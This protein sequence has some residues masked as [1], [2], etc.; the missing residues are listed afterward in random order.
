MTDKDLELFEEMTSAPDLSKEDEIER[1]S[2]KS[3]I[4]QELEKAKNHDS[5][6]KNLLS[7]INKF[8]II[9]ESNQQQIKELKIIKYGLENTLEEAIKRNENL[10]F[11]NHSLRENMLEIEKRI[12]LPSNTYHREDNC[13]YEIK[14]LKEKLEKYKTALLNPKRTHTIISDGK[15]VNFIDVEELK[16]I[17]D[18]EKK[19][20]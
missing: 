9:L 4:E 17:L 12:G 3:K 15:T 8:K 16:Q 14:K 13:P 1:K 11:D 19:I 2:L 10:D 6:V 5:I 7:Q 20:D 18:E